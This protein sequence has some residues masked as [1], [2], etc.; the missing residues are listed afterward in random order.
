MKSTVEKQSEDDIKILIHDPQIYELRARAEAQKEEANSI[1]NA[2]MLKAEE[3]EKSKAKDARIKELEAK[4]L[5]YESEE[6]EEEVVV[7]KATVKK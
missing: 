3:D 6:E 7:K 5:Q 2:E 4:V 1:E